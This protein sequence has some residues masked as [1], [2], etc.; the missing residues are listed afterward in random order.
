MCVTFV[1]VW[2]ID[3]SRCGVSVGGLCRYVANA[4]VEEVRLTATTVTERSC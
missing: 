1:S 3:V 4:E 2:S